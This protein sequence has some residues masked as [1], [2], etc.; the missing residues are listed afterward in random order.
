[1]LTL[2]DGTSYAGSWVRGVKQGDGKQRDADGVERSGRW[3]QGEG[4]LEPTVVDD[5]EVSA[6]KERKERVRQ[7]K[8]L[9]L[10]LE[11]SRMRKRRKGRF[12]RTISP[13]REPEPQP[14][15]AASPEPHSRQSSPQ[16]D[17]AISPPD[18]KSPKVREL[19]RELD[20]LREAQAARKR[21]QRSDQIGA[22][23]SLQQLS[24]VGHATATM[25]KV[26]VAALPRQDARKEKEVV[27]T[28]HQMLA[29]A[30]PDVDRRSRAFDALA[31][32]PQRPSLL[33]ARPDPVPPAV[34]L[35]AQ[36]PPPGL[37]FMDEMLWIKQHQEEGRQVDRAGSP[38]SSR[39]EGTDAVVTSQQGTAEAAAP[40]PMRPE[41][42]VETESAATVTLPEAMD[43]AQS[44]QLGLDSAHIEL[45]WET[46]A[47]RPD[48]S[49]GTA[50]FAR[51]QAS[52]NHAAEKRIAQDAATQADLRRRDEEVR[53]RH[54]SCSNR[55]LQ[56]L[57]LLAVFLLSSCSPLSR[58][59]AAPCRILCI[60]PRGCLSQRLAIPPGRR[61][62][63][64]AGESATATAAASG[65]CPP[66][67]AGARPGRT[68]RRDRASRT[69]TN[70]AGRSQA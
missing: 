16:R 58:G 14:P 12:M 67:A 32:S 52:L 70:S 27:R 2:A 13:E 21:R 5:A 35:L 63:T 22:A 8:K 28:V 9:E 59:R 4:P 37:S 43:Y 1:M 26:D 31:N 3:E 17:R 18:T 33:P 48:G 10:E 68:A 19:E 36:S 40:M 30:F 45:I 25:V 56:L 57:T 42:P 66:T 15:N 51:F 34:G 55:P 49:H 53:Q 20:Q 6:E 44:S 65:T 47:I 39:E 29:A 54:L 64:G 38:P 41:S 7:E 46:L 24:A 11:I 69:C 50:D 62:S 61:D 23:T 60:S